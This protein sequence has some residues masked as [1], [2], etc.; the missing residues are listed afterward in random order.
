MSGLSPVVTRRGTDGNHL[1]GV[2]Q[3]TAALGFTPIE[4]Q[5]QDSLAS[6]SDVE[7]R[8]WTSRV[9]RFIFPLGKNRSSSARQEEDCELTRI[10]DD[11]ADGVIAGTVHACCH[12]AVFIPNDHV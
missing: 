3:T 7:H 11:R 10:A 6:S 1:S 9:F 12:N 4:T 8:S 5:V 2:Q